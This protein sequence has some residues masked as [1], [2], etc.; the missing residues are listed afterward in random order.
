M[1]ILTLLHPQH[2]TPLKQW[3]FQNEPLIRIGRAQ[4][5]HVILD[6]LLVSRH[7]LDLRQVD[8]SAA[9]GST[10]SWHLV[11]HS[12]NGTYI[13]GAV[14]SQGLIETNTLLQLAQGG[15]L[16]KLQILAA[17]GSSPLKATGSS[18]LK[19]SAIAKV[20]QLPAL[21]KPSS[22]GRPRQSQSC[23]HAGNAPGNLFCMHCGLPVKVEKTIRQYQVLRVL[24][25]GGM[26]T[27]YLVWHPAAILMSG[28]PQNALRVLKEMNA[29]M[30]KI[31]KAQELFER[32][33]STLQTLSHPGIPKF[34]DF[35][36][37]AGKKYLV[38]ALLHGQD[39]EKR[40]RQ[41]GPVS[42]QQAIAWMIQTCDVLA[43]L[44]THR[45]PIIHRDI[46]PGNLLV[47]TLTNSIVVLDF[48]AVK[49]VGMPSGTRIGAEGYAAPEQAQGRPVIQSDLYAIGPSL[50]FLIT[51]E[52][53]SRLYQK[54]SQGYRFVLD[55]YPEITLPLRRV[56]DRVTQPRACDRYQSANE[57]RQAL[58]YCL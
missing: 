32:E 38:M 35:F 6:D 15:P 51:G 21:P 57:L 4:G 43:Y 56:L 36:V 31:P 40:I 39:L 47:Q 14:L 33:A 5:N 34:Y 13:N 45:T 24:G 30:A 2:R 10:V 22:S 18:P 41:Q 49:A 9:A 16:L 1:V 54:G 23:S 50:I 17:T 55:R 48:G 58:S 20:L 11:N 26:G 19:Q 46:K 29:D 44:H 8:G 52:N 3:C 12:A 53:P 27:T 25:K 28:Q 37:D 7:H 42:A